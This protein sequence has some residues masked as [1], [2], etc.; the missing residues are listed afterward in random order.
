MPIINIIIA[1]F[2]L[3]AIWRIAIRYR[4]QEIRRLEF[5]LWGSFWIAVGAAAQ[6][7]GLADKIAQT[8]GVERGADLFVYLTL[9]AI[10]FV[11]FKTTV[12]MKRQEREMTKVV[13]KMALSES[14][15]NKTQNSNNL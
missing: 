9:L 13:R 8:V 5:V 11:L 2:V 10:L 12:R 1:V 15:N 14:S 3:L 4:R 6:F 7:R